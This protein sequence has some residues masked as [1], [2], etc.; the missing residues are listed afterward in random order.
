[1][2]QLFDPAGVAHMARPERT[3]RQSTL[4][5]FDI[6]HRRVMYGLDPAIPYGTGPNRAFGTAYHAGLEALYLGQ[7]WDEVDLA[8]ETAFNAEAQHISDWGPDWPSAL[9]ALDN[10]MSLVRT[11]AELDPPAVDKDRYDV[12][13]VEAE[14]YM[15]WR[16][17]WQD[18]ERW[19]VKGA[20]D[21]VLWDKHEQHLEVR[22]HK[23]ARKAWR[24][25]KESIR[26]T[27]QAAWYA[28]WWAKVWTQVTQTEVDPTSI[29]FCFDVMTL[30][31]KFEQRRVAIS[32]SDI[33]AVILKANLA[34]DL[35]EAD[36]PWL[37]NTSSF[38]C[39]KQYCDHWAICPFGEALDRGQVPE[40]TRG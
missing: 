15:P 11:Y 40:V 39:S 31:G 29:T 36:G 12:V 22:D 2:T 35:I 23:T 19:W 8:V 32:Q 26:Q 4:G 21:L 38:L 27:N 5:N 14:F 16:S 7:P 17:G 28:H 34:A 6:C 33:N 18:P 24:K 1:M 20:L 25:G 13:A 37:P 9:D 30:A 10:A 3:L